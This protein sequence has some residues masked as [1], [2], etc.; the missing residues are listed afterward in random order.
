MYVFM[1]VVVKGLFVCVFFGG[2][3]VGWAAVIYAV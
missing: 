3:R 1:T 2:G